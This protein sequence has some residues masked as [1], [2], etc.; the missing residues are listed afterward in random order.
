MLQSAAV[1]QYR[2]APKP[3]SS[4]TTRAR[5]H[6]RGIDPFDD[7]V[8]SGE[9]Y[10]PHGCRMSEAMDSALTVSR[11]LRSAGFDHDLSAVGGGSL[12]CSVCGRIDAAAAVTVVEIARFEGDSNPDDEEI[13]VAALMTCGHRGLFGAAYGPYADVASV[14]VLQA[15]PRPSRRG[16]PSGEEV[17]VR[18]D[19]G[20]DQGGEAPC[21]AHLPIG[22]SQH[23]PGPWQ[24][25]RHHQPDEDPAR[26]SAELRDQTQL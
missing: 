19:A 18:P 21:F 7:H 26:S 17:A 1:G 14:D 5:T 11:R 25:P 2:P 6:D 20:I 15:L 12:R 13:L 10:L 24:G 9:T 22:R 4:R 8:R 23:D 3:V 16:A